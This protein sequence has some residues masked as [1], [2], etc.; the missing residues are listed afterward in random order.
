MTDVVPLTG[1]TGVASA[2]DL[3]GEWHDRGADAT[4][5]TYRSLLPATAPVPGQ[6]YRFEVDL[7]RCTGCKAC[8]AACHSLNGLDEDETWRSVGLLVGGGTARSDAASTV[9]PVW[10][11]HV[12]TACH[13]CV[14]PACLAGCP[15]E[16][17]EKDPITGIVAH[18]DDQ[19]IGCRYCMLTCPY[20]IPTFN[21]RLGVV[22]K[23][24]MCS[25]RLA[26]GEEPACVQGCP[27]DAISIGLVDAAALRA[28]LIVDPDGRLVP[29][30]PLSAHTGPTTVYLTKRPVPAGATAADD[31]RIVPA[32]NHPPLVAMLVLTQLSVGA[33]VIS[34]VVGWSGS[35]PAADSL[36][37]FVAWATGLVAIGA[38][39]L[40]LGRPLVAWR[41]VLG[42]R[43]SWLSREI[44]AFG[45]YAPLGGAT[46][47]ADVGWL[48]RSWATPLAIATAVTGI[49]GV[50]C[51]AKLYAVTGRPFWRL[52]R[53]AARFVLGA[54]ATGAPAIGLVADDGVGSAMS[55][56]VVTAVVSLLASTLVFHLRH[57]GHADALGRSSALLTGTLRPQL[58]RAIGFAV[59]AAGTGGLGWWAVALPAALAAVWIERSLFFVAASP[60]R[61]PGG[62]R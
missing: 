38:S 2:V 23:C 43:H 51:S 6:Q 9:E 31:H 55:V 7:D 12:T 49:L 17:Y 48:S 32:H 54:A 40:H 36:S 39:V 24:D 60:D 50:Y 1:P 37:A 33:F 28:D 22:R 4:S 58:G 3:F 8:V 5:T 44:V 26:D 61:M 57:R 46:A 15:V 30:A 52:D 10:H 47:A 41:A 18:L 27:T 16:A 53:S 25:D 56:V 62:F 20:E 21:D 35:G 14:E 42:L 19:C 34:R 29:T 45:L 59:L 11:Q 13:H